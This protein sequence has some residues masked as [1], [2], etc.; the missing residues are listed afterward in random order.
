MEDGKV[1]EATASSIAIGDDE[2]DFAALWANYPHVKGRS[3]R[4][5]SNAAWGLMPTALSRRMAAAAKRYAV[6]GT[7]PPGGAPALQKWIEDELWRDWLDGDPPA[8]RQ[9]WSGPREVRNAFC[10][11]LGEEWC[12]SYIDPCAW[13]DVPDRALIPAS[14]FGGGKI[15]SDGGR[16]LSSLS[17]VVL[18]KERAA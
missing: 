1:S 11:A 3:S 16:V 14:K 17:L 15:V 2:G 6:G 10:A 8:S 12:R 5:K 9:E 13:Q 7:I 18:S 4:P